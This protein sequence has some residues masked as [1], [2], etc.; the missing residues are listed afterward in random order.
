MYA[1]IKAMSRFRTVVICNIFA[2]WT[3]VRCPFSFVAVFKNCATLEALCAFY[4]LSCSVLKVKT[5]DTES[6]LCFLYFGM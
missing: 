2:G 1:D 4:V 6:T 3:D 5:K